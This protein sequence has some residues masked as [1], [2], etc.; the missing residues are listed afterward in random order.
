MSKNFF[1]T[2]FS[3]PKLF[4]NEY[5]NATNSDFIDSFNRGK[6]ASNNLKTGLFIHELAHILDQKINNEHKYA[7]VLRSGLNFNDMVQRIAAKV[8]NYATYSVDEFLAEYVAGRMDGHK[9]AEGVNSLFYILW[10]GPQINFP[11]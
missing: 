9:Y 2:D 10:G 5:K 7:T 3:K 11:D 8:S 4:I 6:T 1:K